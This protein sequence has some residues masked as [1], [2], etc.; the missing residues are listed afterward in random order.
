MKEEVELKDAVVQARYL[1]DD[2]DP[3]NPDEAYDPIENVYIVPGNVDDPDVD[4]TERLLNDPKYADSYW[5]RDGLADMDGQWDAVLIDC[6]AT[7]GRA[8]VTAFVALD[9]NVDGEV[10][11]P[12]L[13]T[14]KEGGALVRLEKKL[15][16]IRDLRK[17]AVKGIQP[18]MRHVLVCCAPN[19]SFGTAEHRRTLGEIEEAY[20]DVLLP[21]VHW[22]GEVPKIYRDECPVP[23]L[24]PNSMPAQ[25]Y[26]KVA[27]ALGFPNE[28]PDLSTH[29]HVSHGKHEGGRNPIRSGPAPF[30][31][32]SY[33]VLR[34]APRGGFRRASAI[35]MSSSV[36]RGGR[37]SCFLCRGGCP[38]FFRG[39]F[40][41]AS[42]IAISSSVVRPEPSPRR[43]RRGHSR[44]ATLPSTL[45]RGPSS[46]MARASAVS[47]SSREGSHSISRMQTSGHHGFSLA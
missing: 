24:A 15:Q 46:S 37:S 18:E 47:A 12:I 9:K 32:C 3:A 29:R 42:A 20:A 8:T 10:V 45:Y 43:R 1:A 16:E 25:E 4:E 21:L 33:V 17:Y 22:S 13:C 31:V 41:R 30:S 14:F 36:V 23:I 38:C 7:Y 2:I 27:T 44:T 39:G 19:S 11:P 26:N 35:A 34:A 28:Q 5:I 40:R 6:P